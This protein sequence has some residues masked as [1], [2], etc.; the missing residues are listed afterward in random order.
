MKTLR[1]GSRLAAASVTIPRMPDQEIT[2]PLA[3]VGRNIGL[4]RVR[5]ITD[6]RARIMRRELPQAREHDLLHDLRRF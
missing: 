5:V 6:E 1:V 4:S 2:S 3:T